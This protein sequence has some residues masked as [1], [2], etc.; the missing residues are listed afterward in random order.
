MTEPERLKKLKDRYFRSVI[1]HPDGIICHHGDCD[2]YRSRQPHCSCGLLHDLS[3]FDQVDE[4]Y[5][6]YWKDLEKQS[7]SD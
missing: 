3:Y 4:L 6:K 7:R 2:I 5:P 1:A